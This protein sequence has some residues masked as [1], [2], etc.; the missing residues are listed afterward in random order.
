MLKWVRHL[1]LLIHPR[2]V[3][4]GLIMTVRNKFVRGVPAILK[5]P[6]I[7]FLCKPENTMRTATAEL[8]N[9]NAVE[10]NTCSPGPDSC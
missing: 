3:H 10:G 7:T 9:Q 2:R 8:G 5:S 6:L 4:Q 1:D